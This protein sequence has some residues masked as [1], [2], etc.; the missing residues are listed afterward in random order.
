M[1]DRY[2]VGNNRNNR[3]FNQKDGRGGYRSDRMDRDRNNQ[4]GPPP[5]H[6]DH[7]RPERR[8]YNRDSRDIEERMPKYKPTEGAVSN[9]YNMRVKFLIKTEI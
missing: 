8:E 6:N 9:P 1:N 7:P 4:G 2:G 5:R 3:N